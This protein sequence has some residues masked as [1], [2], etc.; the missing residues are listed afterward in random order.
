MMKVEAAA[1]QSCGSTG[2]GAQLV[3]SGREANQL[4]HN[5]QCP[6]AHTHT[7]GEVRRG[8]AR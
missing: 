6:E 2:A 4:S 1:R 8:E 7:K 5:M 3:R